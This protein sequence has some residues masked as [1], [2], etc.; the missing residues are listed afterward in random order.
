MMFLLISN[1]QSHLSKIFSYCASGTILNIYFNDF[2][3]VQNYISAISPIKKFLVHNLN[4]NNFR[5]LD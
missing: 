1:L 4:H 5:P 2:F 3:E